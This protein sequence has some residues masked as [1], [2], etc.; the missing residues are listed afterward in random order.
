MMPGAGVISLTDV[1]G[2]AVLAQ[3]GRVQ[4]VAV[5]AFQAGLAADAYVQLFDAAAISDVTVGTTKPTWVVMTD[6]G[7][8]EVSGGDG[9]PTHGLIFERGIVVASTTTATGLTGSTQ[10]VRLGFL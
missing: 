10:Q 5:R 8:G 7:A 4:L 2:T 1:G 6:F 9:L 3:K